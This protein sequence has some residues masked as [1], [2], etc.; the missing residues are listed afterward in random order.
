[1]DGY[2]VTVYQHLDKTI[3]MGFGPQEIGRYRADGRPL[4]RLVR[5]PRDLKTK[6]LA[7][8]LSNR[9]TGHLMCQ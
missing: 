3:T 2:R 1:M 9:Q 7:A 8:P 6:R 5:K 4:K